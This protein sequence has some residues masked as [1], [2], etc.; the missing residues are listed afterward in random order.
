MKKVI[1]STAILSMLLAT[2]LFSMD[3]MSESKMNAVVIEIAR[4]NVGPK[5]N[6]PAHS[7]YTDKTEVKLLKGDSNEHR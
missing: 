5:T 6:Q 3:F 4:A 7:T 1:L 2:H